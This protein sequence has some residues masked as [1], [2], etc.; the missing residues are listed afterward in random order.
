MSRQSRPLINEGSVSLTDDYD[1]EEYGILDGDQWQCFLDRIPGMKYVQFN[2]D[3]SKPIV[4]DIWN[5]CEPWQYISGFFYSWYKPV[6]DHGIR[7]EDISDD[8]PYKGITAF[9]MVVQGVC[10][11]DRYRA[12]DELSG[13]EKWFRSRTSDGR[14]IEDAFQEDEYWPEVCAWKA[15]R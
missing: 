12:W 8:H 3:A 15:R 6:L 2:I 13:R 4:D 1:P 9:R 5:T 11:M 10:R 14:L 7:W